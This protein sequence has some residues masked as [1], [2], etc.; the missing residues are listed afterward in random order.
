MPKEIDFNIND[1]TQI[2]FI[3]YYAFIIAQI[4]KIEIKDK[5]ISR[6][7]ISKNLLDFEKILDDKEIIEKS[8]KLDEEN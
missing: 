7:Y 5:N 8:K 2:D 3:Y 6:E 4:L 1:D